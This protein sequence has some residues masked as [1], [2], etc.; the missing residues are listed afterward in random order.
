MHLQM[1]AQLMDD[2]FQ[3]ALA[4]LDRKAKEHHISVELPDDLL[5]AKMD[6]RLIIQVIINIVNN[7]VK[8]T[9]PG[10]SIVLRA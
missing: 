2:V 6:V 7:A 10:S 3:E 9:P 1:N 8:Y 4:H 5:M